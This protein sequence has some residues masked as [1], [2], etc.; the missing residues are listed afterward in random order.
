MDSDIFEKKLAIK[1]KEVSETFQ[2]YIDDYIDIISSFYSTF[3]TFTSLNKNLITSL[4]NDH[5]FS[6]FSD[7]EYFEIINNLHD[8]LNSNSGRLFFSSHS[9]RKA[10]GFFLDWLIDNFYV[11][12]ST[13]IVFLLKKYS[14]IFILSSKIN[15]FNEES[16]WDKNWRYLPEISRKKFVER[17]K[18]FVNIISYVRRNF[19][20][21]IFSIFS[22][23]LPFD[24]LSIIENKN[25]QFDD[26]G[27]KNIDSSSLLIYF[28]YPDR[29]KT[30]AYE[31][32]TENWIKNESYVKHENNFILLNENIFGEISYLCS[33]FQ[34]VS[35][36]FEIYKK[37]KEE[38]F[39]CLKVFFSSMNSENIRDLGDFSN[40]SACD[41]H[42]VFFSDFDE[43]IRKYNEFEKEFREKFKY[44]SEG[45]ELEKIFF[46]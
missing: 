5:F 37:E 24:L 6:G 2:H 23:E 13:I 33:L 7:I 28:N 40:K 42:S 22:Y 38:K 34:I 30:K 14:E 15:S 11:S 41:A 3:K 29:K 10:I 21:K 31:V 16:L 12:K 43:D 18:F 17:N 9:T 35:K 20:D 8:S 44:I 36:K 45:E 26:L 19:F 39:L 46:K 25:D 1:N 32:C 27:G 4:L